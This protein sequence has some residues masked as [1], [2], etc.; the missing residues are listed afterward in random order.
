VAG[1]QGRIDAAML[2]RHLAGVVHPIHYIAGP[3]GMVQGLRTMLVTS[4]VDE[5]DIRTE[6][7]TGY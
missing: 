6:E 3:S 1:E 7:F 2:E 5:V 4:G